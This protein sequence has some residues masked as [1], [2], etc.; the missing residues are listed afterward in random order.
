MKLKSVVCMSVFAVCIFFCSQS[1][2]ETIYLK[3]GRVIE[4]KI[5]ERRDYYVITMTG[6]VPRRYYMDQIDTIEED[7]ADCI[8]DGTNIDF[9]QYEDIPE[10]RLS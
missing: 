2:S 10:E 4:E 6:N 5:I 3:D 7:Q 8:K 9:T 1:F